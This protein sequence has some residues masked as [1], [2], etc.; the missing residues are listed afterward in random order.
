VTTPTFPARG[1]VRRHALED[2]VVLAVDRQNRR[3]ASSCAA[4]MNRAPETTSASLF[5]SKTRRPRRTAP[6]VGSRPAAPT[7]A[8]MTILASG[9]AATASSPAS[10]TMTS[11]TR[12]SS[13]RAFDTRVGRFR[14]RHRNQFRAI[15]AA[16]RQHARHIGVRAQRNDPVLARDARAI[17]SSVLSPMEPVEPRIATPFIV[18][19]PQPQTEARTPARQRAGCRSGPACRHDRAAVCRCL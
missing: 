1:E 10:P 12:P 6:R 4:A 16:L 3:P 11:H 9:C 2:R 19:A 17:T 18:T 5:A 14:V 15:H 13:R 7:I 8:A